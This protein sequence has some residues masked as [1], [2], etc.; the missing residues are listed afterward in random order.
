MQVHPPMQTPSMYPNIFG[1]SHWNF[2]PPIDIN[3]FK[4]KPREEKTPETAFE[5]WK[6]KEL[7]YYMEMYPEMLCGDVLQMM[8]II[9]KNM[10]EEEKSPYYKKVQMSQSHYVNNETSPLRKP[11]TELE[12]NNEQKSSAVGDL[13]Q[14][15]SP[16]IKREE[17]SPEPTEPKR[18]RS[19]NGFIYFMSEQRKIEKAKGRSTEATSF[20]GYCSNLWKTMSDEQKKEYSE[21]AKPADA[22]RAKKP[23]NSFILFVNKMRQEHIKE[24]GYIKD[25]LQFSKDMGRVWTS[26]PAENKKVYNEEARRLLAEFMQKN[27][28]ILKKNKTGAG[29]SNKCPKACSKRRAIAEDQDYQH[30][31]KMNIRM[32]TDYV[33]YGQNEVPELIFNL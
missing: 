1:A 22:D 5:F 31:K 18:K 21:K 24:H 9:W 4:L 30:A 33:I 6:D 14:V 3:R 19:S 10:P 25:N 15:L 27:P 2:Y 7:L 8:D 20:S 13:Q 29:S 28:D 26:M 12:E 32:E 23:P 17:V 16:E 11:K